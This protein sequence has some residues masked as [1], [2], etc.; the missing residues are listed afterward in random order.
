MT[1]NK[2]EFIVG[3]RCC[4]TGDGFYGCVELIVQGDF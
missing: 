3:Y 1:L 2:G 4:V